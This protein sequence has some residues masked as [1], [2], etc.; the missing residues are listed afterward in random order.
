MNIF[1]KGSKAHVEHKQAAF[2]CFWIVDFLHHDRFYPSSC[3]MDGNSWDCPIINTICMDRA[4]LE[5]F[6]G[7]MPEAHV[8]M[9]NLLSIQLKVPHIQSALQQLIFLIDGGWDF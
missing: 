2:G 6:G 9:K 5:N 1:C 4:N 7:R 8:Q 3:H